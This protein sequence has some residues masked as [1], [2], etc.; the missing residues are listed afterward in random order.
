MVL[1]DVLED[2]VVD[3]ENDVGIHLDEAA[4]AVVGE[5]GIAGA[6]GEPFD[7]AVVEA[8]VE[9]RVHHARHRGAGA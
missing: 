5:A 3:A 9:D 6:R 7:G 4:I 1:E 8:E 2:A